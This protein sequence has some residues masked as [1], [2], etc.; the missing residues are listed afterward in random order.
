M[1]RGEH[2]LWISV[3]AASWHQSTNAPPGHVTD[4]ARAIWCMAQ[5]DRAVLAMR[6]VN[7]ALSD[8]AEEVIG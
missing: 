1:T 6:R 8:F 4:D 5:A 3:C 2:A 7:R